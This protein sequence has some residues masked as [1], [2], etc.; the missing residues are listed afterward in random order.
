MAEVPPCDRVVGVALEAAAVEPDRFV[1]PAE[2][3]VQVA[4]QQN[5]VQVERLLRKRPF[6]PTRQGLQFLPLLGRR[7]G[8]F[9]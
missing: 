9:P 4:R 5:A 6:D 8:T 3:V 1:A 2:P 7:Y